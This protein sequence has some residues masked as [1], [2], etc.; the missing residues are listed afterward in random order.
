MLTYPDID[1][2]AFQIGPFAVHWYGLMYAVG[3]F[4]AWFL[5]RIRARR[6]D[7]PIAVQQMD[8]LVLYGALG[9][10]IG[11]RVGYVF[12]YDFAAFLANPLYLFQIWQGGMSFHGGLI[13]GLLAFWL[14]AH[15]HKLNYLSLLDFV[16]P[17]APFGLGAGRLGN[18]I[19]GELWGKPTDLPW[20]M[21]YPPLGEMARHPSQLYQMVLEGVILFGAVWWFSSKPR[22]RG[23]VA[24]LF[25]AGY[26]S[27]RFLVEFARMP[28]A[29]IGYL[30]F[31]W[32]TMGQILSLPMI[33]A[34]VALIAWA[35]RD[36]LSGGT[37]GTESKG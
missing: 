14:F 22:A 6:A 27:F 33:I 10:I 34:G 11:G 20:G 3:F 31:G 9:A 21:V 17:L 7:T 37:A 23:S 12:V 15:R 5:G 25:L 24:G 32:L 8:D 35:Y 26:G 36:K 30:A 18:F 13:G 28:D 29:H 4:A 19:N 16:A 1:P 2:V